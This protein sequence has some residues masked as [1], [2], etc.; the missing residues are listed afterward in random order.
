MKSKLSVDITPKQRA[1]LD[2]LHHGTQKP[3]IQRLL[4][5]LIAL[6]KK[7]GLKAVYA[8]L[9]SDNILSEEKEDGNNLRS[10]HVD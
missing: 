1:F 10:D 5:S 8:L 4:D 3:L 7:H 9:A 2:K 6:E